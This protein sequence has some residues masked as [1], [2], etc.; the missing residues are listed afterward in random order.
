MN[1]RHKRKFAIICFDQFQMLDL[2][3]PMDVLT[4]AAIPANYAYQLEVLSLSGGL[5]ASSSGLSI[6]TEKLKPLKGYDALMVM[7]G[8][9]VL[10]AISNAEII[11]Y[12]KSIKKKI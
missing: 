11:K 5:V 1:T 9:G 12:I 7:G 10:G 6:H 8:Q 4:D 2:S 3:G